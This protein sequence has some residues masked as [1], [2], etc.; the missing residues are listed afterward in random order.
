MTVSAYIREREIRGQVTF[1]LEEIRE[2]TGLSVR[3]VVTELQRQVA[4]G[5]IT[6]PY[7]GFY[8]V[9]PPQYA[10]K[11]IVPPTYYIHECRW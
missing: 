11:G 10:L 6:I 3:S 1:T 4:R 8:V 7:R 9:V 5:R 2:A